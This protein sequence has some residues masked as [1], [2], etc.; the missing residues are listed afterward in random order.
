MTRWSKVLTT[1]VDGSK[2][3]AAWQRVRARRERPR[4]AHRA[5]V[6]VPLLAVAAIVLFVVRAWMAPAQPPLAI[7]PATSSGPVVMAGRRT[8]APHVIALA[9]GA[10]LPSQWT[11]RAPLVVP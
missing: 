4:I 3:D 8:N 9:G 1:E 2:L 7:S 5:M 11:A 10:V 6:L